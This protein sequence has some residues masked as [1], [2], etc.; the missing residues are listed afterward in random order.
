VVAKST[1]L[2]RPINSTQLNSTQLDS[3]TT[4]TTKKTG[5]QQNGQPLLQYAVAIEQMVQRAL[6]GL[7]ED[8]IEIEAAYAFVD[9][10]KDR[11]VTKHLTLDNERS[12]MRPLTRI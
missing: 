12:L 1:I 6:V 8:F 3:T 5:T 2:R 4:T 7:P 11:D 9:E 10:A